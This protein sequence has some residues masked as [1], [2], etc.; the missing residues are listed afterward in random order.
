MITLRCFLK[1]VFWNLENWNFCI[2]SIYQHNFSD[3]DA[4]SE[5]SSVNGYQ[6]SST[7]IAGREQNSCS[8]QTGECWV[9][10]ELSFS[11]FCHWKHFAGALV[12]QQVFPIQCSKPQRAIKYLLSNLSNKF[13]NEL[14][15]SKASLAWLGHV[16]RR[17]ELY[18]NWW[19]KVMTKWNVKVEMV[20]QNKNWIRK[21]ERRQ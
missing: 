21:G 8:I 10:K 6:Q 18:W 13:E 3:F 16:V 7:V 15:Q 20:R 2:D 14:Q 12:A 4:K 19:L 17:E 5:T 11:N 1:K 9:I